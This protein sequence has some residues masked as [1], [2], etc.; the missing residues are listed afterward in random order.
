MDEQFAA[1]VAQ[2]IRGTAPDMYRVPADFFRN[3]YPTRG[4]K[5]LPKAVCQRL[6]GQGREVGS[7]F[8]LDTWYDGGKTHGLITLVHAVNGMPRGRGHPQ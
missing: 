1:D 2:V 8:R 7:V 4:M 6:S 3:S 5:A